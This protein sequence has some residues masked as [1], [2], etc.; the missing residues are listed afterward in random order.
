MIR[1]KPYSPRINASHPLARGLAACLSIGEGFGTPRDLTGITTPSL[2]SSPT[3]NPGPY[4][5]AVQ[6][7]GSGS[8]IGFDRPLIPSNADFT[9]AVLFRPTSVAAAGSIV[10][11]RDG[12]AGDR[13]VWYVGGGPGTLQPQ[14][15]GGGGEVFNGST[16]LSIGVWHLA[17]LARSGNTYTQ[18]LN[19]RQDGTGTRS[20]TITQT[21]NTALGRASATD[22]SIAIGADF[23][24]FWDWDRA[25]TAQEVTLLTSDPWAVIRPPH[26]L[27]RLWA[28]IG[29]GGGTD[30]TV[31]LGLLEASGALL[32]PTVSGGA[33]YS[34]AIL[35]A[36]GAI[37]TPTVSA[38]AVYA[39]S[40]LSATGALLTPTVSGG[41][42]VSPAILT[43]TA[44][45]LTPTVSGGANVSTAVLSSTSEVLAPTVTGHA[46][47]SLGIV[48]ATAELLGVTVQTGGNITVSAGLL[49]ATA[50]LL[51]PTVSASASTTVG[52]LSA[53]AELLTPTTSG[54]A[55]VSL[56]LLEASAE[57]LGV[58]VSIGSGNITV[59]VGVLEAT[60][61][62]LG[63]AVIGAGPTGPTRFASTVVRIGPGSGSGVTRVG[64][65]SDAGTVSGA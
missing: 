48:E 35:G 45:Q 14:I 63:V 21:A 9:I 29:G 25:L 40:L 43:A 5:W 55:L 24:G 23:A 10:G 57:L 46:L 11:Q 47:V 62:L 38:G 60:A 4:G 22:N 61:E 54:G 37:L 3:W 51:S 44:E 31:S 17:V 19:G 7:N 41:A 8:G 36:D 58:T 16:T 42:A 65:D 27:V 64:P 13:L 52:L 28:G 50:E 49:E 2:L 12:A 32:T 56:G 34:A 30:V 1:A 59:S 39:A 20:G 26:R 53:S 15:G 33:S 6:T 18:W